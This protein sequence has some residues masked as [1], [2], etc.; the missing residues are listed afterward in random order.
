MKQS[1]PPD[2]LELVAIHGEP[3]VTELRRH[4]P[5]VHEIQ[6]LVRAAGYQWLEH[7]FNDGGPEC[8]LTLTRSPIPL[9]FDEPPDESRIRCGRFSREVC[10][11]DVY[12]WLRSQ[13][14]IA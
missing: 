12:I 14:L 5:S 3:A 13:G 7:I 2:F 10:W 9:A 6:L 4:R 1:L 11:L 8:S